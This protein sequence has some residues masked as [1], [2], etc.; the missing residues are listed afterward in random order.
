MGLWRQTSELASKST[1]TQ[2]G[3]KWLIETTN[4][5]DMDDSVAVSEA[6]SFDGVN[7]TIGGNV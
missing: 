6:I 3:I 7:H 1:S 4:C 5:N 2:G